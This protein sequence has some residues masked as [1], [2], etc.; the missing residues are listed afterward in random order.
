MR[1]YQVSVTQPCYLLTTFQYPRHTWHSWNS[2]WT[3]TLS[4]CSPSTS[5]V[6]TARIARVHKT[7]DP[8]ETPY[9]RARFPEH[10]RPT[11]HSG[12]AAFRGRSS[13]VAPTSHSQ[14]RRGQH[15]D[16]IASDGPQ[17]HD[18]Y[19]TPL[20]VN[21]QPKLVSSLRARLKHVSLPLTPID[22]TC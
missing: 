15:E 6:H 5:T 11:L 13:P 10:I 1:T 3:K 14:R 8:S 4:K 9:S 22:Y 17:L 12:F 21:H 2:R 20:V 19:D 16:I 18:T 7:E